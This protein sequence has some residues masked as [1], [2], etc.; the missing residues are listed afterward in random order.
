MEVAPEYA[1]GPE[2]LD[3]LHV[4]ANGQRVPLSA[5]SRYEHTTAEDRVMHWGQFASQSI[6]FELKPG[7]SL[8]Q[9]QATIEDAVGQLA[10]P[11]AVQGKLQGNAAFFQTMQSTQPWAIFGTLL[12][13]YIVLGVLYESYMHPLTILS[14]LP[15]AGVGALLAL[16]A[17]KTEFSLIAMLGLF[18]LVGVVMKN[19]ILMIDV[20]LQ[21]E[22]EKG[23]APEVAI[24]E[25]CLLRLRPILM[26][27]M[28]A[29]LGTMP[30]MIGAGEGSELRKP[31][32]I[33]IVGGLAFSQILTLY[34]TPVVY[35]YLD[36]LRLWAGR[37]RHSTA[38]VHA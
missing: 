38:P 30:L 25:A 20:A 12:I 29:M 1:R 14:T 19:A 28:A 8:S 10:M 32:G 4:I 23:L 22:R 11:S 34:T 15:S 13:V 6:G 3:R 2:A 7:V 21:L 5:F 16:Q 27:T 36:R 37:R 17:L 31:L 26:T 35:L 9:A 18:L 24:R 33:A